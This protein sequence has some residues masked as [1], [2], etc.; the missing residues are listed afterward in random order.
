MSWLTRPATYASVIGGYV[1]LLL[2]GGW[3]WNE[4]KKADKV[5]RDR[6][7]V[8]AQTLKDAEA[9]RQA[10]VAGTCRLFYSLHE[11]NKRTMRDA[12]G[13]LKDE[14]R[15]YRDTVKFLSETSPTET[16]A[17]YTAIKQGL[18]QR[19]KDVAEAREEADLAT[20]A[21]TESVPPTYCESVALSD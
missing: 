9:E 15:R 18:P 14:R 21:V 8:V 13:D 11:T 20:R 10:R 1:G 5:D 17:L 4:D 2:I 6:A 12:K 16:P 19:Q 3:A 7:R